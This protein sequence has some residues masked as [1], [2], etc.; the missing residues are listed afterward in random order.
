MERFIV[1]LVLSLVLLAFGFF[2]PNAPPRRVNNIFIAILVFFALV[3]LGRGI[4]AWRSGE[5]MRAS[6]RTGQPIFWQQ[7]VLMGLVALA[8]AFVM[9]RRNNNSDPGGSN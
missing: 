5:G 4:Q 1:G 8:I 7:D 2:S 9:W 6:L 3:S